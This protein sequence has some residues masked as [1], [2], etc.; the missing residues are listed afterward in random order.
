MPRIVCLSDTHGLHDA[1]TVPDGDVLIH[2]GDMS[3]RG[4]A[5]EVRAFAD[6]FVALPH[7]HKIVIAGN[8]D[9]L[10]ER[11]P[12]QAREFVSDVTYLSDEGAQVAGLRVWG[13][14][15][16]PWF[17]DWAFNLPR[18]PAL[19]EKWELIPSDI[20]ILITH[21]PPFGFLDGADR[22]L[23]GWFG[24]DDG[25][26]V[27]HVGCEELR[28]ALDRVQPNLHVFGHIH[29]GYGQARLGATI[30]VNASNCDADYRPVNPPVVVDLP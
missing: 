13:S 30:L 21:G 29:E 20:D 9:W 24:A 10:F 17:Y 8:H 18:G 15:W 19:R 7:P 23:G 3:M 25:I 1:L 2:A 26:D 12:A 5:A 28:L 11:S 6:W 4:R 16:Q 14:P 27:E 22:P